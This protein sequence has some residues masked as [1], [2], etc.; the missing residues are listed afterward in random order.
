MFNEA[1]KIQ[2]RDLHQ[3]R[4]QLKLDK[5]QRSFIANQL[6]TINDEKSEKQVAV[7]EKIWVEK[8]Q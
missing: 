1:I 5:W 3:H 8:H 7:V 6:R 2:V 4:Y